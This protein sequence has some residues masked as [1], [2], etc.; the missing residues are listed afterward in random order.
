VTEFAGNGSLANHLSPAEYPL[1]GANRITRIIVGIALA[2]RFLHS[3][4]FIHFDLKPDNILL[5]WDWNVRI[6][7]FGQSISLN[8]HEIPSLIHPNVI[9]GRSSH[10]TIAHPNATIIAAL[11]EVMFSRLG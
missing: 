11:K 1:S 6:A 8:N 9:D 4:G 7:D 10:L 2:M 5:D 3:R